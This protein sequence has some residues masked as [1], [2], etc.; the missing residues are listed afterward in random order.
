MWKGNLGTWILGLASV[1]I[2]I[3]LDNSWDLVEP[4]FHGKRGSSR[5]TSTII[6]AQGPS[7][8]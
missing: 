1:Y 5:E 6:A 4:P 7:K 8:N 3:T 2:S